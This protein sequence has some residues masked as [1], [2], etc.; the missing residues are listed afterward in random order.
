V[1]ATL[2][3]IG[4]VWTF[5]GQIHVAMAVGGAEVV[6]K[7]LIFYLHERAW[8]SVAWGWAD[9]PAAEERGGGPG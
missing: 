2:T 7:L 5:T 3:T 9:P 4:L 8:D 1:V 6:A